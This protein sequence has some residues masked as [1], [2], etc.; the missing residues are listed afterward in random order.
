MDIHRKKKGPH[1]S[2]PSSLF[3][4]PAAF[5][6]ICVTHNRS[7]VRPIQPCVYNSPST[8]EYRPQK[9]RANIEI[10]LKIGSRIPN[11]FFCDAAYSAM[12][13]KLSV[14]QWKYTAKRKGRTGGVRPL[15]LSIGLLGHMC[16]TQPLS[17]AAFLAMCLQLPV[18]EWI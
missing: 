10:Y 4:Y 6:A 9:E 5:S 11:L 18:H 15:S 1:G 14:Y 16:Y 13:H 7:L 3:L 8:N 17:G 2:R 12:R